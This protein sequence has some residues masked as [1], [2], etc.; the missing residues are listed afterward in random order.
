MNVIALNRNKHESFLADHR[1][2][3]YTGELLEVGDKIVI[4]A[5]CKTAYLESSW[6][7]KGKCYANP[8]QC[9]SKETLREIPN[10]NITTLD[11]KTTTKTK[12]VVEKKKTFPFGWIVAIILGIIILSNLEP[13]NKFK[14]EASL[15]PSLKSKISTYKSENDNAEKKFLNMALKYS[16]LST[17][18]NLLKN[19]VSDL[20]FI[21]GL[22]YQERKS[23]DYN[24]GNYAEKVFFE[25]KYPIKLSSMKVDAKG[26][27][28]LIGKIY[29]KDGNF[30]GEAINNEITNGIEY[31][32]FNIVLEAGEYYITHEGNTDLLYNSN[33]NPYPILSNGII[34]ITGTSYNENTFYMYYY[35]WQISLFID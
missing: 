24:F 11:G 13:Y 9:D 14:Q 22:S 17:K 2:D 19:T 27:G 3:P 33:Y 32:N 29:T 21:A 7:V 1:K 15:V 26:T 25:V 12:V 16:S 30:V 18:Y 4:C 8:K 6:K 28:Y 5:K 35:D 23:K 10:E 34:E 20:K 31:L